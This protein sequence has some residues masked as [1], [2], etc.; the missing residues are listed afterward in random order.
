MNAWRVCHND[1]RPTRRY[2]HDRT[3]AK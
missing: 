2:G 3:A 1:C